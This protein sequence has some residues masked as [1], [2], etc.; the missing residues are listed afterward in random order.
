MG[1]THIAISGIR[2]H[3]ILSVICNVDLF[4]KKA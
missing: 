4:I 2:L 3:V 1:H